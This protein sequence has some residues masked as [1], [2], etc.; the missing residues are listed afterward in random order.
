VEVKLVGF[1][2]GIAVLFTFNILRVVSLFFTGVYF[3]KA[4]DFMHVEVWQVL[5]IL[6]AIGLWIFWIKWTRKG[7]QRAAQ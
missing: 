5:F 1:F 4:F 6:F 7:E 2:I 3:P